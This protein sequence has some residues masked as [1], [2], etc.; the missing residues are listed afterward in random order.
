LLTDPQTAAFRVA[1]RALAGGREL[2]F[3]PPDADIPAASSET[4]RADHLVP[5]FGFVGRSYLHGGVLVLGI[6]PGNGKP[7]VRSE[8]DA[9][10]MPRLHAFKNNPNEET[11]LNAME[12]QFEVYPRW[13]ASKEINS[14]LVEAGIEIEAIAYSNA[15]PY[16]GND[17][18][19][20]VR[21]IQ[22]AANA[23]VA[24]LVAA[25]RPRVIVAHG[26]ESV[27]AVLKKA[28][29]QTPAVIFDRERNPIARNAKNADFVARLVAALRTPN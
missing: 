18:F 7:N 11:Y 9:K 2:F 3:A 23:W 15:C 21:T 29:V 8:D 20:H 13:Q 16:R 22:R 6:N 25:L 17:P 5:Q 27:T 4:I 26:K 12:A 19:R 24:P 10:M 1:Q 28:G 14:K